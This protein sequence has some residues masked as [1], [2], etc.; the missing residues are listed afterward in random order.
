MLFLIAE[1]TGPEL[2]CVTQIFETE[3]EIAVSFLRVLNTLKAYESCDGEEDLVQAVHSENR[4]CAPS[5]RLGKKSLKSLLDMSRGKLLHHWGDVRWETAASNIAGLVGWL[6]VSLADDPSSKSRVVGEMK[7]K[8][9]QI[10]SQTDLDWVIIGEPFS[11]TNPSAKRA[12]TTDSA[13]FEAGCS[14]QA[15]RR[16][17]KVAAGT[18]S[19]T[20]ASGILPTLPAYRYC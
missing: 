9:V 16:P 12:A 5:K 2:V 19:T 3:G 6:P 14:S 18:K 7:A 17:R 8:G 4:Y 11:D 1:P 20:A 13:E 10:K 15:G